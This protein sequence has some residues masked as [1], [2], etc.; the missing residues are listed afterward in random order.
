[1]RSSWPGFDPA[2]PLMEVLPCHAIGIAGSS[3]A[4]T[5][6]ESTSTAQ[7][8]LGL[9]RPARYSL[10]M[11]RLSLT[12]FAQRGISASMNAPSPAGEDKR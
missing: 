10:A 12:T 1:M 6:Y 2:I 3:P 11:I 4:M 7:Y 9:L 8:T 5:A